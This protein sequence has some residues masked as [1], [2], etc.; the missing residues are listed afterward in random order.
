MD[1]AK[2]IA[3]SCKLLDHSF[4]IFQFDSFNLENKE[5]ALVK[6]R[7]NLKNF[8]KE[9]FSQN[10]KNKHKKGSLNAYNDS[11]ACFRTDSGRY[12]G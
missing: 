7:E 4:I 9:Y 11:C 12:P 5:E 10:E 6:I 3:Y 8:F 2:S 1:T